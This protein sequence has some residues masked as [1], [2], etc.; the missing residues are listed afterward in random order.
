MKKPGAE[1][2][3]SV[4]RLRL[5]GIDGG[6]MRVEFAEGTILTSHLLI[7]SSSQ[8]H[9]LTASQPSSLPADFACTL[10]SDI[11]L[12]GLSIKTKK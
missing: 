6:G 3:S 7:F 4:R 1:S 5:M 9:S 11:L 10:S 8:L 12:E 2:A